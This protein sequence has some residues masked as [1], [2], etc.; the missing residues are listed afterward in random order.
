MFFGRISALVMFLLCSVCVAQPIVQPCWLI[1]NDERRDVYHHEMEEIRESLTEIQAF[2]ASEMHRLG[3][4]AKTFQFETEI[5]IYVGPQNLS[6]YENVNRIRDLGI[7]RENPEDIL[8]VY[9]VGATSIKGFQG[10]YSGWCDDDTCRGGIVVIPLE[11]RPEY[12]N[13]VIAHELSHAFGFDEH[14][15]T[16][17][18]YLMEVI[19]VNPRNVSFEEFALDK[20]K[21]HPDTAKRIN[22]SDAL[23]VIDGIVPTENRDTDV[24]IVDID[25]DVNKDGYVDLSDVMIVR[26]A[27]QN[28]TS[29]DTDVNGDGKTDEADV[30]IVKL[31]AM[32][33]IVAAAPTLIRRKKLT[34]W[35]ALKKQ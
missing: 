3:Y 6:F 5:P 8:L 27:I 15:D 2:F 12:M 4:G 18:N 28:S 16:F 30:N 29:Y 14:F 25:A 9:L 31:K 32:E 13:R 17:D 23:S 34:T 20:Y 19:A 33:A 26:S 21:L 35:G 1:P 10:V 11:G 22:T 24:P 7:P